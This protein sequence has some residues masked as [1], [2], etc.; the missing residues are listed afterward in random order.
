MSRLEPPSESLDLSYQQVM[1]ASGSHAGFESWMRDRLGDRYGGVWLDGPVLQVAAVDPTPEDL[2]DA[3]AGTPRGLPVA[4]VVAVRYSADQLEGFLRE[5]NILSHEPVPDP[6]LSMTRGLIL[7]F[8]VDP[9]ANH[10][11]VVVSSDECIVR[12]QERIPSEAV[13]I[14][15]DPGATAWGTTRSH[16]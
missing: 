12:I 11:R 7:A 6:S 15:V 13:S 3:E 10:L 14:V 2:K 8:W 5:L 9:K 1:L 16:R 4:Q